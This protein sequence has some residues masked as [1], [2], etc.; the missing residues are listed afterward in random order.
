MN[1]SEITHGLIVDTPWIDYLLAGKKQWEMRTTICKRRGPIA[2]IKKGSKQVVG[3]A[4]VTGSVGPLSLEQ[5]HSDISKHCVPSHIFEKSNYNWLHAWQLSAIQKLAV[6]VNYVHKNGAVIWVE[7]NSEARNSLSKIHSSE[8]EIAVL[9][10][11]EKLVEQV[12][13]PKP[14]SFSN[15]PNPNLDYDPNTNTFPVARDGSIFSPTTCSRNG[16]Y[17]V[18]EKGDEKKFPDFSVALEYLRKMPTA[19]WRRPN[20]NG[21]WGIVS[22]TEW[23]D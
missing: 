20:S 14:V 1:Y 4:I 10:S 15:N 3:V 6:P 8:A 13:N 11:D 16:N 2:L 12:N 9:T 7:L 21:N 22:A 17:T 18:G 19:K 23:T 5:L